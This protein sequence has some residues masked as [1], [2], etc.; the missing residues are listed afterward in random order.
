MN[1][2]WIETGRFE[3]YGSGIFRHFAV[4][5]THDPGDGYS[6]HWI[7]NHQHTGIKF[8]FVIVQRDHRLVVGRPANDYLLCPYLLVIEGMKW[9]TILENHVVGDVDQIIDR[10]HTGGNQ[11]PLHPGR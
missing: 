4:G 9:L 10:S 8:P 7:G 5:A 11:S 6:P 2:F 1:A 3:K